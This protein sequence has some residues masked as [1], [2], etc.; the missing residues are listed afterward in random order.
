MPPLCIKCLEAGLGTCQSPG[1]CMQTKPRP[2][3]SINFSQKADRAS[4]INGMLKS[5]LA[6][7]RF[8]TKP[9]TLPTLPWEKVREE[10]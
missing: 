1:M 4:A 3:D 10:E 7:A 9:P 8:C 6:Q 5:N 2:R